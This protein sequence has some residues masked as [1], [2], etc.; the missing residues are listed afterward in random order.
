MGLLAYS[1]RDRAAA[2]G[3]HPTWGMV[4]QGKVARH[5]SHVLPTAGNSGRNGR[6]VIIGCLQQW[7]T[8]IEVVSFG[9]Q[10]EWHGRTP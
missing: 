4:W 2:G 10:V 1:T 6:G 8:N 9:Q 3:V 7:Q 5:N